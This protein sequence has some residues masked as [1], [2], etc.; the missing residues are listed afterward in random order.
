MIYTLNCKLTYFNDYLLKNQPVSHTTQIFTSICYIFKEKEQLLFIQENLLASNP[1]YSFHSLIKI[2]DNHAQ[3]L[4]KKHEN[5][6]WKEPHL[7]LPKHSDSKLK[8]SKILTRTLTLV[9]FVTTR[10]N[11]ITTK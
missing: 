4:Y 2:S 5:P 9:E 11:M 7:H 8:L 10:I 1:I 6:L 3:L